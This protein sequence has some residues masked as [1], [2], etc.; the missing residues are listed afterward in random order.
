[1]TPS[2]K[3]GDQLGVDVTVRNTGSRYGE[4][5]PQL[6]LGFPG[7][8]GQPLR[9]LRGVS[10][11][12]LQ[13][14]ESRQ[15]HFDLNARDLSSVTMAGDRVVAPGTYRITIGE[16]QPNTGVETVE[17]KLTVTGIAAVPQ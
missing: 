15:V 14:G 8:P 9:A 12:A 4:A 13:A 11:V 5:V 1:M 2:I 7:A 10:R 6:Y 17:G 16:G 3:A